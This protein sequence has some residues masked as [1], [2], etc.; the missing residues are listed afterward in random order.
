M[1]EAY[2]KTIPLP[3]QEKR[4]PCETCGKL[5]VAKD[6]PHGVCSLCIR[7]KL[8]RQKTAQPCGQVEPIVMLRG[9][10]LEEMPKIENNSVDV[11][12]TSPPYNRK[13]NDKYKNYNDIIDDYFGFLTTSI[14]EMIRVARGNVF[15]NIQKNYY[16]KIDVY[17]LFGY[18]SKN[19]CEVFIWEKSNPMPSSGFNITNAYEFIIVFGSKIKSNSTYTKNHITTSVAK[20]LKNH[21][22]I[23]HSETA[24]FFIENFTHENDVVFDPF[25][26]S[27]TTGVLC[28]K[29]NRRFIGIEKDDKYFEIAKQRIEAT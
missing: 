3:G 12:F 4:I 14:N 2:L 29:L 11:V 18:F 13:R 22:A 25:M 6:M 20:M 15:L 26:G 28:K 7:D 10:C 23:M 8:D 1:S 9:D 27:G 5:V 21:K 16:N 17:R 24:R 19:I